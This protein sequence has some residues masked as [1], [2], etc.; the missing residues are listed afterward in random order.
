MKKLILSLLF[1]LSIGSVV[2]A[3]AFEHIVDC[4]QFACQVVEVTESNN[5]NMSDEAAMNLMQSAEIMCSFL[6]SKQ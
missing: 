5:G 2:K 1:V 6:N 3:N 4:F